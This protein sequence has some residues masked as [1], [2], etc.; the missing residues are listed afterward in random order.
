MC[1]VCVDFIISSTT[2][3]S[4]RVNHPGVAGDTPAGD[5]SLL[6][7]EEKA[8]RLLKRCRYGEAGRCFQQVITDLELV[9]DPN[10]AKPTSRSGNNSNSHSRSSREIGAW[11]GL[12]LCLSRQQE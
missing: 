8:R 1:A 4:G 5:S 7:L 10:S 2:A 12:A 11:E 6:A 9:V 3:M